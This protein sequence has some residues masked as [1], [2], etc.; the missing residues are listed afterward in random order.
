MLTDYIAIAMRHARY[1]LLPEGEGF[2]GH[3]PQL[4]GVWANA[5]TLEDTREELREAL[6]GWIALALTQHNPIP[7][8]EEIEVNAARVA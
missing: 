8:I 7:A 1:E 4:P 5:D 6:E 3:I 2:Y